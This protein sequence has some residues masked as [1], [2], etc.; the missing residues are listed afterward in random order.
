M[1]VAFLVQ[2]IL[3][4]LEQLHLVYMS[5]ILSFFAD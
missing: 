5:N 2:E 4:Y 3:N 1:T